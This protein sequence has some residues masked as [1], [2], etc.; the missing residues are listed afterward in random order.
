[1][2]FMKRISITIGLYLLFFGTLAFGQDSVAV[3][4]GSQIS[5]EKLRDY[6]SIL[7]SDALEGRKTATRG[8]KMAAAFI[9]QHFFESGLKPIVPGCD[10][11]GYLQHFT[12]LQEKPAEAWI[13]INGSRY[14][15]LKSVVYHGQVTRDKAD[16]LPVVFVG[17]GTTGI[18]EQL[19]VRGKA[20]AGIAED[21]PTGQYNFV[22]RAAELGAAM[23]FLV[24]VNK[25]VDFQQYAHQF[26]LNYDQP[27]I[28]HCLQV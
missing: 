16:S 9:R 23:T 19:D 26:A 28:V 11:P 20:V 22:Q 14:E 1:M 17:P 13:E 25:K 4:F 18:L 8:Q 12:L 21:T 6:L 27:S 3:R 5:Q 7:A 24:Y 10:K 15:N 2:A